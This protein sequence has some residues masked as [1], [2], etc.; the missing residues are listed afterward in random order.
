MV[1]LITLDIEA[2]H[3]IL[4]TQNAFFFVNKKRRNRHKNIEFL[5]KVEN[6]EKAY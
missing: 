4:P 3:V 5:M 6:K 1:C 2:C